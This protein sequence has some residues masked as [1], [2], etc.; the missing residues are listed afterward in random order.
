M[1]E[2]TK[3]REREVLPL[4]HYTLQLQFYY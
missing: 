4:K 1:H 3:D 2:I